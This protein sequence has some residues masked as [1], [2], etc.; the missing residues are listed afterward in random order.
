G[1]VLFEKN[2]HERFPIASVTKIMSM[3]IFLENI[4]SGKIKWEDEVLVSSHAQSMIG[5]GVFLERGEKF[6]V[7]ELFKTVAVASANDATVA[8]AEHVAGSEPAFVEL[9]NRR[10]E[11]LGMNDTRFM[12]AT[13]LNDSEYSTA[14]DVAVMARELILKHPV[15][16]EFTTIWHDTFRNGTHDV[17][18]TNKL[19][20]YFT[21]KS[22]GIVC[23]G[24]KTGHTD[25]AGY[26]LAATAV[27][28]DMRVLA[29]V[30]NAPDINTRFGEAQKLMDY[31]LTSFETGIFNEKDKKAETAAVRKGVEL[32]VDA[33]YAADMK[34]V[35]KKGM[36]N[37]VTRETVL[38]QDLT[39]PVSAGQKIGEVVFMLEGKE[40]A[41]GD[42]LA[43]TDV[44]KA[45]FI[46]L[47]F[48]MIL[49]WLGIR[50]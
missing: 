35:Y 47:F 39:A 1:S 32:E 45:S 16:F 43:A 42:L 46:R 48:R 33:V 34:I 8:L 2:S 40:V 10:A 50:R 7:R 6:T 37:K 18:N 36:G 17:D 5:S 28:E 19:I 9:M 44:K 22:R 4:D 26:C 25:A 23:D 3:L 31:G 24:L 30:L 15:I 29:V 20:R 41:R 38:E 27:R 13:G 21:D 12:D 11:S 14:A 49:E